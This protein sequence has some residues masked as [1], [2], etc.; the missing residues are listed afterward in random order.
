MPMASYVDDL[1]LLN[2][3]VADQLDLRPLPSNDCTA[4]GEID[5]PGGGAAVSSE[6]LAQDQTLNS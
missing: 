3:R 1:L 6:A 5:L 2:A 4:P